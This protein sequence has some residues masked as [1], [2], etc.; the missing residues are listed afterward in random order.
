M[1]LSELCWGKAM[2][3]YNMP[4]QRKK[5]R[6]ERLRGERPDQVF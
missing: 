6:S 1:G 2:V 5:E 3:A 4:L